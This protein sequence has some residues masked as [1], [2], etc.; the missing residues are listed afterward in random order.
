[1]RYI[2]EGGGPHDAV[3]IGGGVIRPGD[4]REFEAEPDPQRWGGPWRLL[5]AGAAAADDTGTQEAAPPGEQA[6]AGQVFLSISGATAPANS[7][8]PDARRPVA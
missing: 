3:M 7:G 5:P 4:V 2:Y 6:P 8:A 1:M